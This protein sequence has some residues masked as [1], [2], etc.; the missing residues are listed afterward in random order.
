VQVKNK[1]ER[2]IP[3]T[4]LGVEQISMLGSREPVASGIKCG[5][6][7]GKNNKT[8][9]WTISWLSLKTKVEQGRCGGQVMSGD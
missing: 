9:S 7:C 3:V 5:S 6:H 1:R 2:S 4:P 8:R